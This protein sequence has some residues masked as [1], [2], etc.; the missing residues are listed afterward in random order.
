MPTRSSISSERL[1]RPSGAL[2]QIGR[3]LLQVHGHSHR[4]ADGRG[5]PDR[6]GHHA[7]GA[8]VRS[9]AALHAADGSAQR[10]SERSNRRLK[11]LLCR[12]VLVWQECRLRD[13]TYAAQII[14]DVEYTRGK[15]IVRKKSV[16][17]GRMPIMLRSN[18]CVLSGQN[19][20]RLAELKEC[21]YD[22]GARWYSCPLVTHALCL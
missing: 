12:P 8:R 17:I 15:N 7:S 2:P 1:T 14:V 9:V 19:E 22:P 3:S 16:V 11:L 13:M 4:Q 21:P 10:L 5:R 20:S 18:R 6:L